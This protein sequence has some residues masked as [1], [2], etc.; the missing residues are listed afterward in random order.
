VRD[1]TYIPTEDPRAALQFFNLLPACLLL[2]P[3]RRLAVTPNRRGDQSCAPSTPEGQPEL[4]V[5][6]LN[7]K[8]QLFFCI[9]D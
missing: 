6:I 5:F 1:F 4:S 7:E 2:A 9:L 8:G 3:L